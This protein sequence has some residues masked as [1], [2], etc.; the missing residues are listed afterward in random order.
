MGV[1][2]PR[3]GCS[4]SSSDESTYEPVGDGGRYDH[5]DDHDHEPGPGAAFGE[6][7]V[8]A[9]ESRYE[10]RDEDESGHFAEV[11]L[12]AF[13]RLLLSGLAVKHEEVHVSADLFCELAGLGDRGFYRCGDVVDLIAQARGLRALVDG[14]VGLG[15]P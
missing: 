11:A 12:E 1:Q 3:G 6:S 7:G 9:E 2:P 14:V 5:E 10:A 13:G 8:G 15:E 4:V